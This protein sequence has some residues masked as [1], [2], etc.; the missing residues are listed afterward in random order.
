MSN[1]KILKFGTIKEEDGSL[2]TEGFEFEI[3]DIHDIKSI[4]STDILYAISVYLNKYKGLRV[5][6]ISTND[7]ILDKNNE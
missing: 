4:T 5:S 3:D 6:D 2:I 7:P 1:L